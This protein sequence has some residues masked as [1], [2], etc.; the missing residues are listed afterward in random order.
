MTTRN[1]AAAIERVAVIGA[2]LMGHGIALE[3]AVAGRRVAITDASAAALEQGLANMRRAAD[4]LAGLGLAARADCASAM[5]RVTAHASLA[6][7]VAGADLVVEAV[8]EDLSLKQRV[9][10]ELDR[11]CGAEVVLASNTS[12]FMPSILAAGSRH[13]E[14]ILVAH[15]FNPPHLLPVVEIVPHPGT[16][17]DVV[18]RVCALYQSLG[19]RPVVLQREV[20][21]FIA[22]RLQQALLREAVALVEGGVAGAADVDAVVSGSFGRRLAVAGPFEVSDLAGL[23][24]IAAIAREVWPDLAA[25]GVAD[26][27]ADPA[28]AGD[29]GAKTGRGFGDWP[30]ERV[31]AARQRIATALAAIA[32]FPATAE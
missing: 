22:N 27:L 11:A 7:A 10:A 5:L 31:D 28:A 16:D 14:R 19:K 12:T 1:S 2:G 29:Y 26:L 32:A 9:F 8:S 13:P 6:R 20:A 17:V 25:G 15:Y 4:T 3:F 18:Q 21:G 30:P 23:D 24:V